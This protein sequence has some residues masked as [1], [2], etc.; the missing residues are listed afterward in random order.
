MHL[1]FI[2]NIKQFFWNDTIVDDLV[3][4]IAIPLVSFISYTRTLE[5]DF[6]Y[7]SDPLFKSVMEYNNLASNGIS[8]I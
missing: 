5:N 8:P 7:G 3:V 2:L 1:Y 6:P 4:S